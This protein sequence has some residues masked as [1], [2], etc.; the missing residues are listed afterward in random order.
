MI[1][2]N[3][4]PKDTAQLDIVVNRAP[5]G[6][7]KSPPAYFPLDAQASAL[8]AL[9]SI[10]ATVS[11]A[12]KPTNFLSMSRTNDSIKGTYVIDPRIKIPASVLP[13]LVP[14]ESEA[15]R[16]NVF[17]HTKNGTINVDLFIVDD[18]DAKGNKVE[19]MLTSSNGTVTARIHAASSARTP[20]HLIAQSSNGD[21]TLY[22][23]QSFRGP[24]TLR[25]RN[26]SIRI[27][28][29]L[30]ATTTM[31][32]EADHTRRCFVG[33]FSDWTEDITWAGDE[34]HVES[35]NGNV[36]LQYNAEAPGEKGKGLFGRL[37]GL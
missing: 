32:G 9:P 14:K 18:V 23:P 4:N 26:G 37:F 30:A 17:L 29:A 16:R 2:L 28:N 34:V 8:G 33:D 20:F 1:T 7:D 10:P 19:M 22:L 13:T 31:F 25:T 24:L 27:S 11:D 5:S 6:P 35:A 3:S 21:V 36:K 12:H 15:T